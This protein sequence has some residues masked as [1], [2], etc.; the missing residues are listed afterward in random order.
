MHSTHFDL[1]QKRKANCSSARFHVIQFA[2]VLVTVIPG[3]P[4]LPPI[5]QQRSHRAVAADHMFLELIKKVHG[6][7]AGLRSRRAAVNLLGSGWFLAARDLHFDLIERVGSGQIAFPKMITA[8]SRLLSEVF[9]LMLLT[10]CAKGSEQL[11]TTQ[12]KR[13]FC[14]C[15]WLILVVR[16]KL[17]HTV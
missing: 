11:R 16:T 14:S 9:T 13:R 17:V 6:V 7:N 2:F 10:V 3:G 8:D 5:E 12:N 15:G 1:R 4:T